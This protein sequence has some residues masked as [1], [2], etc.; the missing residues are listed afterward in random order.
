MTLRAE[1]FTTG[2][3]RGGLEKMKK[4]KKTSDSPSG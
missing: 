2:R 4:M 1:I 3:E